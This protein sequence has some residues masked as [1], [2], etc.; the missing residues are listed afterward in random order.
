MPVLGQASRPLYGQVTFLPCPQ[1]LSLTPPDPVACEFTC[2]TGTFPNLGKFQIQVAW[3][4]ECP[5][6][7]ATNSP[8]RAAVESQRVPLLRCAE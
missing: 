7:E 3:F 2:L 1:G 4:S 5:A 6:V 8:A